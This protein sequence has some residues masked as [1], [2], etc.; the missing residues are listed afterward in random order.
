MNNIATCFAGE[1]VYDSNE[2]VLKTLLKITKENPKEL[3]KEEVKITLMD[4]IIGGIFSVSNSLVYLFYHLAANPEV[5]EKL[6]REIDSILGDSACQPDSVDSS[7][8]ANMPYLKACVNE[9]FRLNCPV[10]GIMRVTTEPI[11]L[12]GYHIPANVR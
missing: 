2:S 10:P 12:S 3:S 5:Q 8:L 4:F 11:V 7:H 6:Y 1:D 9:S